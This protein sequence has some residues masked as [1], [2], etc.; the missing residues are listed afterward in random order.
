ML[1]VWIGFRRAAVRQSP[2]AGRRRR[3]WQAASCFSFELVQVAGEVE[4]QQ[5]DQHQH[6]AHEREEEELDGR[7]FAPRPAPDADEEVH[8]QQHHFP[9]HVEQEEV[10][11]H[12]H[13]QHARFQHQ[14]QH[15]VG[16][17]VLVDRP[18]GRHRQHAQ[19][20]GQEHQRET[21]AVDAQ[22]ILDVERRNPGHVERLLHLGGGQGPTSFSKCTVP[23]LAVAGQ[24]HPHRQREHHAR[25]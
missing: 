9:E 6:A 3:S 1:K 4:H 2:P 20:R 14:K 7:I 17:H 24:G 10:Q 18:T 22:E 21:D 5:G 15:A 13:A 16:L 23:E 11:R 12:E 25:W 19:E 8:R